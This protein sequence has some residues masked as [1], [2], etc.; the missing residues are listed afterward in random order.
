MTDGAARTSACRC[1]SEGG[2]RGR[3]NAEALRGPGGRAVTY[4][5]VFVG[6]SRKMIIWIIII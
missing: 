2:E 3:S 5:G 6:V 1:L 4:L